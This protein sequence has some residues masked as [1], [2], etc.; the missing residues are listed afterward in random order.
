VL[1]L[2]WPVDDA[3]HHRDVQRLDAR[4]AAFPIRHLVA[5]EILDVVGKR[6]ERGGRGAPATRTRC[7]QRHEGA[8]AHALE[9]F[10][11]HRDFHRAVAIGLRRER[12]ADGVTDTLLEQHGQ[13]RGRGDDAF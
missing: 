11:R 1:R 4:I 3:A 7:H 12:D 10:L 6:L 9:Q 13:R 2:A 8:K 5:D